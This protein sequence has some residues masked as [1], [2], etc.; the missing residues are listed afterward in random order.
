MAIEGIYASAAA[1]RVA[2]RRIRQSAH[3][4]ANLNTPAFRPGRVYASETA[5]GGVQA[6]T[7]ITAQAGPLEAGLR[8][9]DL[10][11]DGGGFFVVGDEQ[12]GQLYTRDGNFSLDAE[13][14]LV[15]SSGR[16]VLPGLTVP[17]QAANVHVG[18]QG[19]VQALSADGT[20][21]A[22]GRIDTASFANPAGLEAV[23]G[24]AFRTTEASGPPVV[25]APGAMG[26]GRLVSGAREASGVRLA[27]EMVNQIIT[28]RFM[29]A[30]LRALDTQDDMVGTVLDVI[31]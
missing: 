17:P 27:E 22:Q 30:N 9:L 1:L 19:Q 15:D 26:H 23:G 10:A 31:G 2:E 3:N 8:P 20:I 4:V 13:G 25:D 24:N 18:H 12:G 7:A 14:R 16:P 28:Q 5:Q 29:E 11:I 21:L 6:Q